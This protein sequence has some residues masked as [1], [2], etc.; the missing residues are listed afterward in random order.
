MSMHIKELM[1]LI[2]HSNIKYNYS[3]D[4][5]AHNEYHIK[6]QSM[7]FKYVWIAYIF[8]WINKQKQ[9][10]CS[11]EFINDL[12]QDALTIDEIHITKHGQIINIPKH[13][14]ILLNRIEQ[15]TLNISQNENPFPFALPYILGV[16]GIFAMTI[17]MFLL[18]FFKQKQQSPTSKIHIWNIFL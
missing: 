11:L 5:D 2:S 6:L 14:S 16:V 4:K 8:N 12:L 1:R 15:R 7:Q 13:F 3:I 10:P 9:I 17:C 18:Y